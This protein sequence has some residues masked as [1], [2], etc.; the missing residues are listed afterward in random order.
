VPGT[1]TGS[2]SSDDIWAGAVGS[3]NSCVTRLLFLL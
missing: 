2:G 3:L 1:T